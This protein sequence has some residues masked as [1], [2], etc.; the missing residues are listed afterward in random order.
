M[1]FLSKNLKNPLQCFYSGVCSLEEPTEKR[2]MS[3]DSIDS[4]DCAERALDRADTADR[5]V[6]PRSRT[7]LAVARR[8]FG[9]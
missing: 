6:D 7:A 4:F 2:T 3:I 8:F 5:P 9:M 1:D